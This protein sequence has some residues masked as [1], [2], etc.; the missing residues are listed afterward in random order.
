VD[1]GVGKGVWSAGRTWE[2]GKAGGFRVPGWGEGGLEGRDW[3]GKGWFLERFWV[4]FGEMFSV[5][6]MLILQSVSK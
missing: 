2:D 1:F 5:V 4:E 6:L 3:G